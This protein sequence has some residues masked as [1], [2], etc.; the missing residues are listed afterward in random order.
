MKT[1]LPSRR[2]RNDVSIWVKVALVFF[3]G[4]KLNPNPARDSLTDLLQN[5]FQTAHPKIKIIFIVVKKEIA[6]AFWRVTKQYMILNG[7]RY[8]WTMSPCC[9]KAQHPRLYL[10]NRRTMCLQACRTL[11]IALLYE[12]SL[13]L[14]RSYD[15]MLRRHSNSKVP[16][17]SLPDYSKLWL[18]K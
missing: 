12:D 2:N 3:A 14:P 18:T 10:H 4:K 1:P 17:S 13:W 6:V 15:W 8:R 16:P 11:R 9:G 5:L 7:R